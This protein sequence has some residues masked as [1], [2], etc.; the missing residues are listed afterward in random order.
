MFHPSEASHGEMS[1]KRIMLH[2][3]WCQGFAKRTGFQTSSA[4]AMQV[5]IFVEMEK[6]EAATKAVVGLH[7][8]YF[9]QKMI[10]ATFFDENRF[11]AEDLA[12][13]PE[14]LA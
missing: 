10:S 2:I 7:G 12:P 8:R 14:E 6:L 3:C 4:R 1:I 5:R 9:D 11:E 13:R